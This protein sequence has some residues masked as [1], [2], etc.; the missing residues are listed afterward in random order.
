MSHPPSKPVAYFCLGLS[1]T[2]VGCYVALTKPLVAAIPVF[3]LAWLR[4]GI[5]AVA[6]AP[7][8]RKTG[9]EVPMTRQ[10]RGLLFLESFFGNFLFTLCMIT[11]VSLTSAVSAG[12]I[13]AAIPAAV[14]VFSWIFL[15]EKANA[16]TW[17][18]IALAVAGIALLALAPGHPGAHGADADSSSLST[19][20][21]RSLIGHLLLVAAVLCEASYAVIGKKLTAA[22]PP[23]RIT[24]I[25]NLWG[26]ALSTPMG[27]YMALQFDFAAVASGMWWLLL[28]YALA[29]SMWT[30]WLW[31]T[32]LRTVPASQSGIFTVLLP[33]SAA[34]TGVLLLG[35]SLQPLQL[36]ALGIALASVLVATVPVPGRA[37]SVPAAK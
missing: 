29:A 5:A 15:K 3:L 13:M 31:M 35:E 18:A 20:G 24:A 1:M 6:M 16:R 36:L 26:L 17:W 7:W 2:M 30:V 9:V 37:A 22:L 4:F 33:V 8:L 34:L 14:A 27:I 23:K 11:G 25:I 32:G 28:L 19:E 21:S 12:V 10:T